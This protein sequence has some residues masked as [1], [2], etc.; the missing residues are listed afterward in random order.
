M[1]EQVIDFSKLRTLDEIRE[2]FD[3]LKCEEDRTEQELE[4]I[5]ASHK[6]IE[7]ELKELV[8]CGQYEMGKVENDAVDMAKSIGFTASLADG[9]SAKV[10]QLDL[11]KVSLP[12]FYSKSESLR[13]HFSE[14]SI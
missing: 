5:L 2:A 12:Y 14:S 9:V 4:S 1:S 10:K 6:K 8:Q 3:K 13:I 7:N 11:A